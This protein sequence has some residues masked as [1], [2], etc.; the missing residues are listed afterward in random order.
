MKKIPCE[1]C[2]SLAI[3]VGLHKIK[4]KILYSFICL[5]T[6]DSG[7]RGYREGVA[8]EVYSTLHKYIRSTYYRLQEIE[9]ESD[10]DPN[11]HK[12]PFHEQRLLKYKKDL[13]D[14][15]DG[16]YKPR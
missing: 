8:E 9:L 2:I 16:S 10:T 5:T 3:C 14:M 1:E 11:N 7:F 15:I 12:F 13:E 4:C 6:T